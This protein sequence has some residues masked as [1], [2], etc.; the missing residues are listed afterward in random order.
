MKSFFDLKNNL[1]EGIDS[2]S[3][4]ALGRKR[5]LMLKALTLDGAEFERWVHDRIIRFA[6]QNK[7]PLQQL[8]VGSFRSG[9]G[10]WQNTLQQNDKNYNETKGQVSQYIAKFMAVA[11][12]IIARYQSGESAPVKE[13][14]SPNMVPYETASSQAQPAEE[15]QE[16]EEG[17]IPQ[18]PVY[19]K[20][21]PPF[22]P[23]EIET[24]QRDVMDML[25]MIDNSVA[26]M[27]EVE[28]QL[29]G[30]TFKSR[31]R[32]LAD[33]ISQ[34][35][36][37]ESTNDLNYEMV[38]TYIGSLRDT[39]DLN[40]GDG[41]L[42]SVPSEDLDMW[43]A[44]VKK[45]LADS[46]PGIIESQKDRAQRA[47]LIA[48]EKMRENSLT[49]KV[50]KSISA[51]D[52]EIGLLAALERK[53]GQT[54][55]TQA[56][57][58]KAN[59]KFASGSLTRKLFDVHVDSLL[60]QYPF[61]EGATYKHLG[62]IKGKILDSWKQS[63]LSPETT[64]SRTSSNTVKTDIQITL[65]EG[66]FI[67]FDEESGALI[68]CS[69]RE[70]QESGMCINTMN[71][72]LKKGPSQLI[73]SRAKETR[74]LAETAMANLGKRGYDFSN[75]D[76]FANTL[77]AEQGIDQETASEKTQ[78]IFEQISTL[79]QMIKKFLVSKTQMG[80]VTDYQIGGKF[81]DSS[82]ASAQ[83]SQ[84]Q[85]DTAQEFM[86]KA[87]DA[88]GNL[89]T[90]M[91]ELIGEMAYIAA[92]GEGKFEEGSNGIATHFLS[93]SDTDPSIGPKI[94]PITRPFMNG[95]VLNGGVTGAVRWKSLS[96]KS[97]AKKI[98]PGIRKQ[99]IA[100]GLEGKE[101][102]AYVKEQVL[103]NKGYNIASVLRMFVPETKNEGVVYIDKIKLLCEEEDTQILDDIQG[104]PKEVKKYTQEAVD[105]AFSDLGNL[106][107]FLEVEPED[108]DID[109]PDFG[110]D[111]V[112]A[113]FKKDIED[114]MQ[115]LGI[116]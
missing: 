116:L 16:G 90:M 88:L 106:T 4:Q 71:M 47:K 12:G 26:N 101:L 2:Y 20:S 58:A 46:Y 87:T 102:E 9:F 100:Q 7:I 24:Q 44:M 72:S 57:Q 17:E 108:M 86:D 18:E 104:I 33:M 22:S 14:L 73:S 66:N 113:Y 82:D 107:K 63:G 92:S 109:L 98:E 59:E 43:E 48:Q 32:D 10:E 105:W 15:P 8:D 19:A 1:N 85:I 91:P 79:R 67:R 99:G 110:E 94:L 75:P 61:L 29:N 54:F 84:S 97:S 30:A 23:E 81:R 39:L 50:S 37:L 83:N 68:R 69:Q 40:M 21:T 111:Y 31:V 112:N 103:Q 35:N 38:D 41:D 45:E 56:K 51:Q 28:K 52:S 93:L 96:D 62:T 115:D 49:P 13:P 60:E 114:E 3:A 36:G 89:T 64:V 27:G 42:V 70:V 95:L 76:T 53:T 77:M 11:P 55:L 65:A 74:A 78:N 5:N 80:K 25:D 34:S 6:E